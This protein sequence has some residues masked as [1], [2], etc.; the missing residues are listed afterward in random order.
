MTPEQALEIVS[1]RRKYCANLYGPDFK[2]E[3]PI[4][5]ACEKA[6]RFQIENKGREP[7]T[8]E[9]AWEVSKVFQN[10]YCMG[11]E[12]RAREDE[13]IASLFKKIG[14]IEID[15]DRDNLHE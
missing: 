1:Y 14:L 11:V 7:V 4:Y 10:H 9:E 3:L 5:E 2:V 6:L 15:D 8:P 12:E 13:T